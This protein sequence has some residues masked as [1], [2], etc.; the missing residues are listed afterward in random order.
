VNFNWMAGEII[1]DVAADHVSVVWHGFIQ[2]DET[3]E[4]VFTVKANDGVRVL[5]DQQ[6][7]IEQMTIVEDE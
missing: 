6:V 1:P 3:A 7:L 4:W 5:I 2:F